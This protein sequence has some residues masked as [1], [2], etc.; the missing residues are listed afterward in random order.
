MQDAEALQSVG[1]CSQFLDRFPT[2]EVDECLGYLRANVNELQYAPPANS[3]CTAKPCV[4]LLDRLLFGSSSRGFA[5]DGQSGRLG[6]CQY[7][8]I[9]GVALID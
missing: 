1:K 9:F 5:T 8:R 2:G 3:L 7:G 4:L 6:S